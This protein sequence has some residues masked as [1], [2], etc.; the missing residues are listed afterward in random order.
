PSLGPGL[1]QLE[2]YHFTN[3]PGESTAI[4]R[5]QVVDEDPEDPAS[6]RPLL[7]AHREALSVPRVERDFDPALERAYLDFIEKAASTGDV[8]QRAR[9]FLLGTLPVAVYGPPTALVTREREHAA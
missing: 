6:L 5:L 1:V 8:V 2:A 9:R 4:A 3:A 7:A